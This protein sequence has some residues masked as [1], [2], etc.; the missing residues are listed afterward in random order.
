[1]ESPPCQRGVA[2]IGGRGDCNVG[3]PLLSPKVSPA[4]AVDA[5]DFDVSLLPSRPGGRATSLVRGRLILHPGYRI[6]PPLTRGL[7]ALCADWGRDIYSTTF[8]SPAETYISSAF[9][10]ARVARPGF[11]ASG[12]PRIARGVSSP[13]ATGVPRGDPDRRL[14]QQPPALGILRRLRQRV[15]CLRRGS[16]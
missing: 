4:H 7:S 3:R 1:M 5:W 11:A 2:A 14:L 13:H 16:T 15:Q 8:S 9:V 10:A 12:K 6:R